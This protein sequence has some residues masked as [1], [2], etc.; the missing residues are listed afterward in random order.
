[1]ITCAAD[2]AQQ[3]IADASAASIAIDRLGVVQGKDLVIENIAT[4]PVDRL[5]RSHEDWF[6]TYMDGTA[7]S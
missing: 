4:V 3:I 7:K 1:V 2:A 6:P 5:R